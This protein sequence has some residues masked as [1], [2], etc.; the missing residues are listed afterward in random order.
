MSNSITLWHGRSPNQ[1]GK[2]NVQSSGRATLSHFGMVDLQK[3]IVN[4]MF[5]AQD[6]QPY[7]IL[8][9]STFKNTL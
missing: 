7:Y 5:R 4:V 2:Q 8:A 6:E 3:Q 9:L 1:D